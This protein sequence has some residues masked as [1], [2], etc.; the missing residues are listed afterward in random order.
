[1]GGLSRQAENRAGRDTATLQRDHE[2][3]HS[4]REYRRPWKLFTLAIGLTMLLLGAEYTPAP[5]W[6]FPVS[7]LMAL[8]TYLTAPYSTRTILERRWKSLLLAILL[9]W[10]SI[11]GFYWAY[12]FAVNPASLLMR[13]ANA[14]V[15]AALYFI[16]GLIWLY[17]GSL[18][19]MG[20]DVVKA[21]QERTN[22]RLTASGE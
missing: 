20:N 7:I 2:F 12:W 10:L 8:A 5:D 17:N 15:S 6:D 18:R 4:V 11:D 22:R 21:W 14:P 13:E 1:M 3:W 19:E 9:A 16:C